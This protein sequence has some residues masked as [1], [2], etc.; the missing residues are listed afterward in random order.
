MTKQKTI[1]EIRNKVT[2]NLR[3]VHSYNLRS[4]VEYNM[5]CLI[6]KE[7]PNNQVKI[8]VFG[9]RRTKLEYCDEKSLAGKVRYV[10]KDRI[11]PIIKK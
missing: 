9:D 6:L 2:H 8:L 4:R 7:L 3:C 11:F 5:P 1:E 10:S